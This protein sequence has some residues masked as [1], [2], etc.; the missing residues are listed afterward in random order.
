MRLPLTALAVFSLL[1]ALVTGYWPEIAGHV[2][3]NTRWGL[4]SRDFFENVLVEA[5]GAIVDLLVVGVVLYWF[6]QRKDA[7][8]SI[9]RHREALADLRFY[10][11]SDASYRVLGEVKRLLELGVP[12]LQ[13][14]EATLSELE[15]TGLTFTK[16]DF[17]A[18]NLANTRLSR[19]TFHDCDC[20]AIILVGARLK[21][22]TLKKVRLRRAKLQDAS[23]NGCDFSSCEIESSDFTN[24]DLRSAIF[25]NVDCAGVSFKGADLRSANFVGAKN[26]RKVCKTRPNLA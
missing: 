23:L 7:S 1:V 12:T 25:K 20:D 18:A 9:E 21:H 11:G 17:H 22:V 14:S 6:E 15:I 26:L 4:Y 13:L 8:K 16:T 5:H 10:R 24:A 2:L 3:P 19:T